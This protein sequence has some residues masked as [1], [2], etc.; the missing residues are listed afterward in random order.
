V[1]TELERLSEGRSKDAKAARLAIRM[2]AKMKEIRSEG[3]TDPAL[4]REGGKGYT[5]ATQDR[6]LKK[7]LKGRGAKVLYIRQRSYLAD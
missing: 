2:L 3:P 6:A 5:I 1:R 4:L 7:R